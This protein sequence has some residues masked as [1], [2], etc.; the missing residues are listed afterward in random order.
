MDESVIFSG[1]LFPESPYCGGHPYYASPSNRQLPDGQEQVIIFYN[2]HFAAIRLIWLNYDGQEQL[3]DTLPALG[4]Y[5]GVL[6][7]YSLWMFK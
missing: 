2:D 7:L 4:A 5:Q 6:I 1:L 3:Q